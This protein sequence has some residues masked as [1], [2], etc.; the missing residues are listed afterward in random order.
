MRCG[1]CSFYTSRIVHGLAWTLLAAIE[2]SALLW[3]LPTVSREYGRWTKTCVRT[4]AWT[5]ALSV[6]W[7]FAAAARSVGGP[8]PKRSREQWA[9][10]LVAHRRGVAEVE[11]EDEALVGVADSLPWC[12]VCDNLKPVRTH[13]CSTCSKC[14]VQMDHHCVFLHNCI[15]A[16]NQLKFLQLLVAVLSGTA[17]VVV[18]VFLVLRSRV[19]SGELARELS[20]AIN[21][22]RGAQRGFFG[23]LADAFRASASTC[24]GKYL[25]LGSLSLGVLIGVG[26]LTL[27]TCFQVCAGETGLE[28]SRRIAR[29]GPDYRTRPGWTALFAPPPPPAATDFVAALDRHPH[30]PPH[31]QHYLRTAPAPDIKKDD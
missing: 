14:C 27:M 29:G 10:A 25:L 16:S 18:Y 9:K 6:V 13:H 19:L 30:I 21:S 12:A 22:T 7:R 4:S 1:I 20:R 31:D 28:R 17:Y 2:G 11:V 5:V 8:V 23:K 15:G 26:I 3:A 24:D